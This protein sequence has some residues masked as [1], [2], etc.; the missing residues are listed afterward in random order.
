LRRPQAA[1]ASSGV[2]VAVS[3]RLETFATARSAVYLHG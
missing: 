3:V 2:P 1:P